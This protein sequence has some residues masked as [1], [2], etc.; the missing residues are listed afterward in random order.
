[1]VRVFLKKDVTKIGFAGEIVNVSEGYASNFLIPQKLGVLVTSLNESGLSKKVK[2]VVNR[3]EAVKT[4]T[5]MLAEKIKNIKLTIKTKVHDD[6]KLYGSISAADIVDLLS[7]EGVSVS[8]SQ[9]I[10]DS[11][12]KSVGTFEVTIKLSNSLQ[13]KLTL[14]VQSL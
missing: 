9:V 5:S 3:K 8:K 14:K 10:F 13:P 4:K 12:I 6:N 7:K 2:E 1:M 11:H